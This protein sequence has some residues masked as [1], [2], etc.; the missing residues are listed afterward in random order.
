MFNEVIG[1]TG[2]RDGMTSQQ[3]DAL[4]N[5]LRGVFAQTRNVPTF[6][7]GDCVGADAEAHSASREIG[8][9]IVIRPST[10]KTRAF[11]TG[12]ATVFLPKDPVDRDR[13]IALHCDMLVAAPRET[14]EVTRS[15]T[16]TTARH[17]H[18][19]GKRVLVISP[20]GHTMWFRS[21]E[22]IAA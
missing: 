17:V 4:R 10:A 18:R 20:T 13:D 6:L 16:W 19:L 12:A 5:F 22:D 7:H 8:F 11:C 14:E 15:E 1:F 3:M 9:E 2:T 21:R